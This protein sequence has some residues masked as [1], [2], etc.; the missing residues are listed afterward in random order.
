MP[1]EHDVLIVGGGHAG[2][3]AAARLRQG[4]FAGSIAIACDEAGEPYDRPPLSKDYLSGHMT[5]ERLRPRPSA[6]WAEQRIT[7]LG[8]RRVVAVDVGRRRVVCENGSAIRYGRLIWAAGGT[9]RRPACA[10]DRAVPV[11]TLRNQADA[12]GLR[13]AFARPGPVLVIGGGFIGLEA[14]AVLRRQGREVIVLEAADR[15]LARMSAPTV[16]AWYEALH[17][18]Q[19][20]NV[21]TGAALTALEQASG[22]ARATLANGEE[23]TASHVIAGVGIV[24]NVTPLAEAGV[25]LDPVN[26]GVEVDAFCVSSHTD[27]QVIGDCA[28]QRSPFAE[29]ARVRIESVHNASE[30]AAVAAAFLIGQPAPA[31]GVPW[32]WSNQYD[33]RLQIVGLSAGWDDVVVRGD[34]GQDSFSVIYLRRG[35]VAALDC[36][37]A[38]KDFAHGRRLVVDGARLDRARLADDSLPLRL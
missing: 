9:A 7:L 28:S 17:R 8:G 38:T 25:I 5:A 20:V 32:F 1:A 16:S 4:G 6:F 3:T 15:L 33:A 23:L 10:M 21:R 19:G 31:L 13:V 2:A 29:G 12:D 36:V 35:R 26:G 18:R 24:V 27:I 11:H 37:N 22:G 30:Q 14:A 34:P